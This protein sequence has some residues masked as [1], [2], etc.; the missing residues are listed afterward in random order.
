MQGAVSPS[1]L[2]AASQRQMGEAVCGSK[3]P[4]PES[5]LVP[6]GLVSSW[7]RCLVSLLT[8]CCFQRWQEREVLEKNS[9]ASC[10]GL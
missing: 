8:V 9:S 2:P 5:S 10:R 6:S 1:I 3:Q 4:V 7:G